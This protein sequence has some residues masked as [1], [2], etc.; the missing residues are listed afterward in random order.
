MDIYTGVALSL[1]PGLWSASPSGLLSDGADGALSR[2]RGA[3]PS[4][5]GFAALRWPFGLPFGREHFV[6]VIQKD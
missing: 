5:A 4:S 2:V 1:H 3:D 6:V